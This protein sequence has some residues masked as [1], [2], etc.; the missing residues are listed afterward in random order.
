[1]KLATDEADTT[2]PG[3]VFHTLTIRIQKKIA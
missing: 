1:L 2:L 3:K